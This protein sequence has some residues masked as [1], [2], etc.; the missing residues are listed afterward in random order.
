METIT[1]IRIEHPNDGLGLWRSENNIGEL[2]IETH[3][4]HDVIFE[5]HC[6]NTR[7]PTWYHDDMLREQIDINDLQEY[8]FAF[9]S[10]DQLNEALTNSELKECINDLGFRVLMLDVA[11]YFVS[12]YQAV[13]KKSSIVN[14]KDISFM[15]L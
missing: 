12:E 14:N 5:R 13:F 1:V 9:L 2:W 4:E 11:D 8:N 15:F 3:S 7:F 10:L 6:D